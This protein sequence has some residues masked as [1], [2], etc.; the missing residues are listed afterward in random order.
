MKKKN[1][2]DLFLDSGAFSAMTQGVDIDIYQYIDFIKRNKKYIEVYANLDV[3]GCAEGTWKNQKIM[4]KAGLNPLPVFHYKEDEKYLKRYLKRGHE[5]IALGGLVT[6]ER[7]TMRGFFDR[8][9]SKFLCGKNGMPLVKVH[10]FGMT[11]LDYMLRYPWYSVDSTSWV[12]TG[13]MGGILIPKKTNGKY[14]YTKNPHKVTVSAKSP[15][16]KKKEAHFS[17]CSP[18]QQK[19]FREYFEDQGFKLGK[20]TFRNEDPKTYV[21][22]LNEK[23]N[24]KKEAI[25]ETVHVSGLSNDYKVRD[26]INIMYFHNLQKN[27]TPWP[28]AFK[29]KTKMTSFFD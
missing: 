9:F 8:M 25:I 16:N 12:V 27:M 2:T 24:K 20:S 3:I 14:D 18:A 11:S 17:T 22:G 7:K 13:R 1:K 21:P 29:L 28:W 10:G 26:E 6:G 5:Y 4:E 19:I 15:A 23:W